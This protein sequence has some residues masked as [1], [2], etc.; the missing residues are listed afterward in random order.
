MLGGSVEALGFKL[1]LNWKE[2]DLSID[3]VLRN[4]LEG[5]LADLERM[6][7]T[8][9]IL[10]D[11]ISIGEALPPAVKLLVRVISEPD[12]TNRGI[13]VG[14]SCIL[15]QDTTEGAATMHLDPDLSRFF[16]GKLLP[17]PN[18][19]KDQCHELC[20]QT[21]V[22]TGVTLEGALINRVY[23]F[24]QGNPFICQLLFSYLYGNQISGCVEEGAFEIALTNC[25]VELTSF[26]QGFF[27]G[28]SEEDQKI[29]QVIVSNGGC[30]TM[31]GLQSELLKRKAGDLVLRVFEVCTSMV[32]RKILKD[33]GG[34]TFCIRYS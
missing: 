17:L 7:E 8:V 12:F 19:D 20:V 10:L 27:R 21:L 31:D 15:K 28:L 4:G 33:L 30:L 3:S 13:V 5:L 11:N 26:F 1:E 14:A 24:S 34:K 25:L 18:F 22:G 2:R 6:T 16:A 29:L 9:T 23:E 32:N